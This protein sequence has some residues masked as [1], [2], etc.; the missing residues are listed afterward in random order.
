MK[1]KENVTIGRDCNMYL[2]VQGS[3]LVPFGRMFS[4]GLGR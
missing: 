1:K 4:G 3:G 2:N